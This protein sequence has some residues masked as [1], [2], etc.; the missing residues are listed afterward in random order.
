[1]SYTRL[2][3]LLEGDDDERFFEKIAKPT[4]QKRYAAIKKWASVKRLEP[5]TALPKKN[6]IS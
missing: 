2:F 5:K 3:I 6:S 4:L 1:M